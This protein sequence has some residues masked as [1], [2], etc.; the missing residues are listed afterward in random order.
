[1][2]FLCHILVQRILLFIFESGGKLLPLPVGVVGG[3]N[4]HAVT[5]VFVV[6]RGIFL[7]F[8]SVCLEV[9]LYTKIGMAL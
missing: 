4:K 9:L 8:S 1:M 6:T 5:L 3:N 7:G 2:Y